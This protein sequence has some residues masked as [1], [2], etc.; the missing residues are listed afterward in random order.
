MLLARTHLA[1][2]VLWWQWAEVPCVHLMHAQLY[3][4][5]VLDLCELLMFTQLLWIKVSMIL[6]VRQ[7]LLGLLAPPA[8]HTYERQ[9]AR[10]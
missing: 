7:R 1:V 3:D 6:I 10:G 2:L 4:I 9:G 8:V 5:N